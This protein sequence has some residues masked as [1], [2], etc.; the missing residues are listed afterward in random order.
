M[1]SSCYRPDIITRIQRPVRMFSA[2]R[3]FTT[4]WC[5]TSRVPCSSRPQWPWWRPRTSPRSA[6]STIFVTSTFPGV[7]L[8]SYV[9]RL[10]LHD[11]TSSTKDL[12]IPRLATGLC[13]FSAWTRWCSSSAA[14]HRHPW[15]TPSSPRQ[16]AF[17]ARCPAHHVCCRTPRC[18]RMSLSST[19]AFGSTDNCATPHSRRLVS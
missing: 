14:R 13:R 16:T 15:S 4:P 18:A 5:A 11:G 9:T 10:L 12:P 6:T 17:C 7:H 8:R 1:V 19:A 2:N 3:C